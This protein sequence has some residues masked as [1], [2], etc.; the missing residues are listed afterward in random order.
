MKK[1]TSRVARG[2]MATTVMVAGV[3]IYETP[4]HASEY[5]PGLCSS[6][7]ETPHVTIPAGWTIPLVHGTDDWTV[8]STGYSFR[9]CAWQGT[10]HNYGYNCVSERKSDW[11]LQ[12][13]RGAATEALRDPRPV[14]CDGSNHNIN[15]G[16]TPSNDYTHLH[17]WSQGGPSC[18][19][20]C[21]YYLDGWQAAVK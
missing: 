3:A 1:S 17:L 19:Q 6:P 2:V 5:V 15:W 11:T 8:N 21:P 16:K 10:N 18:G 20:G 14:A 13:V 4:A 9:T 7:D 12:M